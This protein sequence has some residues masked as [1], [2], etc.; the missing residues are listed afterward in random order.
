MLKGTSARA[1]GFTR[2]LCR[3][4]PLFLF[5]LAWTM[6]ATGLPAHAARRCYSAATAVK[7]PHRKLC[8]KAHVYREI[9]LDDGTRI[10]DICSP[11]SSASRCRFAFVSLSQNRAAVGSLEKYVGKEIEVRGEVSPVHNRAE[12]LL[13]SAKQVR[14]AARRRRSHRKEESRVRHKRFHP[15]PELLKSFNAS[16]DRMPIRAPAFRGGYGG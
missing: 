8:V 11:R 5:A 4:S 12:I 3:R 15:N 13:K 1:T 6:L 16:R 9:N 2:L 10:L 7:H 14:V